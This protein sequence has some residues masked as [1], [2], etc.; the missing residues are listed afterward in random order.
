MIGTRVSQLSRRNGL[1]RGERAVHDSGCRCFLRTRVSNASDCNFLLLSKV[2]FIHSPDSPGNFRYRSI[3]QCR[4]LDP[5]ELK[6]LFCLSDTRKG[7]VFINLGRNNLIPASAKRSPLVL[8][9]I[10]RST[11]DYKAPWLR[12]ILVLKKLNEFRRA[13]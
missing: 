3:L 12:R 13:A 10:R 7:Y 4:I 9:A 11:K 2:R 1:G 8:V 5:A 6:V